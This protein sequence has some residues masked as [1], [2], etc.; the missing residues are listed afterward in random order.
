MK[1]KMLKSADIN[2]GD[3]I[4]FSDPLNAKESAFGVITYKDDR[5]FHVEWEDHACTEIYESDI[6][7]E[8]GWLELTIKVKDEKEKLAIMMKY[9][10]QIQK[11][12]ERN[13]PTYK[14]QSQ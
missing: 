8:E 10:E 9:G 3:I 4:F 1:L 11:T 7:Y 12:I 6:N 13:H 5:C 14:P 2:E